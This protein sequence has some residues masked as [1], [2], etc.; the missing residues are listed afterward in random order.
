MTPSNFLNIHLNH[1]NPTNGNST[2]T[3]D[4]KAIVVKKLTIA[5]AGALAIWQRK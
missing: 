5:T 1:G 3:L 2:V 4:T